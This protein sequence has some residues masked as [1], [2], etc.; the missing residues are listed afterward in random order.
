MD[1][2]A[3][4]PT[5]HDARSDQACEDQLRDRGSDARSPGGGMVK[6]IIV[7]GGQPVE[8]A[9]TPWGFGL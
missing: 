4:G 2:G 5:F 1:P 3:I 8:K 6:C 9:L 7:P